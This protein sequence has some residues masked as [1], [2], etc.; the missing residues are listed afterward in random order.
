MPER[1][2]CL[3]CG[4]NAKRPECSFDYEC[5]L[6]ADCLKSLERLECD[7]ELGLCELDE[8]PVIIEWASKI[9]AKK[10]GHNAD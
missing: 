1:R 3:A 8:L 5:P 2:I 6:C 9:G 4:A 7:T 10:R